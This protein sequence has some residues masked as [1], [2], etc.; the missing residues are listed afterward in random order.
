L[1]GRINVYGMRFPRGEINDSI[2]TMTTSP[3]LYITTIY[4]CWRTSPSL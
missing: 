1:A 3:Y 2:Y 4:S